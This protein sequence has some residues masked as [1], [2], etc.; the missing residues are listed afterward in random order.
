MTADL[1]GMWSKQ[2]VLT[3]LGVHLICKCNCLF[4]VKVF[5]KRGG[6]LS[7]AVGI[8][9]FL[10]LDQRQGNILEGIALEAGNLDLVLELLQFWLV[11]APA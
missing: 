3:C 8:G 6:E 2:N 7:K 4:K 10:S 5:K 9:V 1:S 11:C